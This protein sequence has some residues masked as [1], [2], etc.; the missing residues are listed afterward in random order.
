MKKMQK[1]KDI[2][3]IRA[4]MRCIENQSVPRSLIIGL[5]VS[6]EREIWSENIFSGHITMKKM[7]QESYATINNLWTLLIH[8]TV[9]QGLLFSRVQKTWV[10]E[11]VLG[12]WTLEIGISNLV[13]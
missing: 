11:S 10:W 5:Y 12:R 13:R 3:H 8:L 4:C 6:Y 2:P 1:K 7:A 9:M